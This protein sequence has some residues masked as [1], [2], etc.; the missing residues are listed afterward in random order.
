MGVGKTLMCLSVIL[1]TLHQ[2]C[3]PPSRTDVS[4]SVT[5]RIMRTY[6]FHDV[7]HLRQKTSLLSNTLGIPSLTEL[8]A[9]VLICQDHTSRHAH[10]PPT[11]APSLD[12][13]AFYFEF[14]QDLDCMREA[15]KKAISVEHKKIYLANTT[16]LIVPSLLTGQWT[17]EVEKHVDEG[18]LRV[19]FIGRR[20]E[21]PPITELINYDVCISQWAH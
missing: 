3:Q 18:V 13:P 15:K 1:T 9:N 20:E 14:P 10:L 7:H 8:C 2:P 17:Q 21:L 4:Q 11:I 5:D 6:P 12:A 16:L 19:R